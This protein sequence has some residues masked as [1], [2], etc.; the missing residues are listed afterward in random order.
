MAYLAQRFP[1][2]VIGVVTLDTPAPSDELTLEN[3]PEGVWDAPGNDEHLEA[4]FGFENRFAKEPLK[5]Q[6]PLIVIRAMQGQTSSD[7][8]YWQQNNPQAVEVDLNG[9]HEIYADRPAEVAQQILSLV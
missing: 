6:A 1:D 2:I 8:H 9:S 4:L 5:V 7:D 3:F